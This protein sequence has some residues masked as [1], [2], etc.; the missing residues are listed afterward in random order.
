[1]IWASDESVVAILAPEVSPRV[2]DEPVGNVVLSAIPNQKYLCIWNKIRNICTVSSYNLCHQLKVNFAS[3]ELLQLDYCLA[4]TSRINPSE[5]FYSIQDQIF[6]R[7][8]LFRIKIFFDASLIWLKYLRHKKKFNKMRLN[9]PGALILS[10]YVCSIS[11]NFNFSSHLWWYSCL[12]LG[13]RKLSIKI[14][15]FL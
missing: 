8:C 3:W 10:R 7:R 1:M 13:L 12:S 4:S 6:R 15:I 2:F 5:L 14:I 11:S 9:T